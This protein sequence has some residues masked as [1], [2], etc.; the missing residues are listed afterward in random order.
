MNRARFLSL[1][2]LLALGWAAACGG[3]VVVD[4]G[5]AGAGTGAAT[6][7]TETG[8]AATGGCTAGGDHTISIAGFSQA[9]TQSS[10]C[11]PVYEGDACGTCDC[12]NAVIGASA[13][14]EYQAEVVAKSK[15]CCTTGICPCT[16]SLVSCA[17]GTCVLG[18]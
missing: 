2:G 13:T 17:N 9:C 11:L 6:T 4:G 15:G 8:A 1:A 16:E 18:Q 7:G 5:N 12:P 14:G 3:N 10:D